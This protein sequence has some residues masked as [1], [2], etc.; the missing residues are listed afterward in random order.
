MPRRSTRGWSA[1][2]EQLSWEVVADP[3]MG[4]SSTGAIEPLEGGVRF[5]GELSLAGGGGFAS[6]WARPV[7]LDGAA[8]VSVTMQGDGRRYQLT[9]GR[10]DV[11]FDAGSYR[12]VLTL[13][14][15]ELVTRWL[16]LAAF[17]AESRGQEVFGPPA[18][19]TDPA[20]IDRLGLLLADGEAG[21][22]A[23]DLFD[24]RAV[25]TPRPPGPQRVEVLAGLEQAIREGV[26][27]FNRGDHAGCAR[28]YAE[29]LHPL[30]RHA[31]L[32]DGEQQLVALNL[33]RLDQLDDT[34]A[35]W[36]LRGTIDGILQAGPL[37]AESGPAAQA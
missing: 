32:T 35:A 2:P 8:A 29:A 15:G 17:R 24:V 6:A 4:G 18:L 21:P 31:A 25:G 14:A 9:L 33:G 10:A 23:V 7:V 26:P 36:L 13:P 12:A 16:P 11:S 37:A 19:D 20:A 3:V 1:S 28:R 22:F 30:E 27:V 5:A 34:T